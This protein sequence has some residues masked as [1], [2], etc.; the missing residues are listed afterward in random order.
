MVGN[1]EG[2]SAV[3][4]RPILLFVCGLA[5]EVRS[6]LQKGLE[7]MNLPID[8]FD[9]QQDSTGSDAQN[10]TIPKIVVASGHE[11]FKSAR[12]GLSRL[13][14]AIFAI[15]NV[16]LFIPD[17]KRYKGL[18][19]LVADLLKE[20]SEG[21][22]LQEWVLQPEGTVEIDPRDAVLPPP[23]D[24]LT[25][26]EVK[27]IFQERFPEDPYVFTSNGVQ[28]GVYLNDPPGRM[29]I[30]FSLEEF[31]TILKLVEVTRAKSITWKPLNR[32]ESNVVPE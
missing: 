31:Y 22:E 10:P 14:T 1:I 4:A 20:I 28:V 18:G 7:N 26:E 6:T 21:V 8:I 29:P 13:G 12:L 27:K 19:K 32:E 16:D 2:Q 23:G 5:P 9:T 15:P 3:Q 24:P 25:L 30:E 11:A 17:Q